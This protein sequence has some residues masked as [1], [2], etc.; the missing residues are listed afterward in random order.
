ML[1][2]FVTGTGTG[3]GKSIVAAA[4]CA[5]LAQQGRDV[6]ASKPLLSGMDDSPAAPWPHDHEL[7]ALVSDASAEEIA[8][9]RFGPAVSPHLAARLAGQQLSIEEIAAAVRKR[10]ADRRSHEVVSPVSD[11][12]GPVV[13]VEGA[14]GLLVPIDDDAVNM[15]DLASELDLPLVI[16]GHPGLGTINHVLLT[17][18][19]AR[20]R[21][22]QIAGV[23]LTPWPAEP[24]QIDADNRAFLERHAG[25]PV[26]VLGP[27][28][29]P[30]RAAL[31]AAGVAAGLQR[32][33]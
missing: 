20:S 2:L 21:A 25:V 3:V 30:D 4:L 26:H 7:L 13:V 9:V 18:E 6:I 23:V 33:I 32:L 1:G 24:S 29:G 11:G 27:V 17:L 8:P 16:A 10:Y 14:G 28:D 12:G 19:A 31:A 5:A 22:L 15:A